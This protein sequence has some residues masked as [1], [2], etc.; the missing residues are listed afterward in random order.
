MRCSTSLVWFFFK[1]ILF[2]YL[3]ESAHTEARGAA[4]GDGEAG[5]LLSMEIDV[6]LDPGPWEHDLSRRQMLNLLS[7]PGAPQHH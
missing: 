7:H 3:T 1:K 4:E 6:G 2:V 5:S